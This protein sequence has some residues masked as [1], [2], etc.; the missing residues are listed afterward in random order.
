MNCSNRN[1]YYDDNCFPINIDPIQ[2][3]SVPFSSEK[4]IYTTQ[5]LIEN[6]TIINTYSD[7]FMNQM[8]C[9][10]DKKYAEFNN[11][12]FHNRCGNILNNDFIMNKITS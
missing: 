10:T 2:K 6:H 12:C 3:K 8:K 9:S 5:G 4:K 1:R 7:R 11:P